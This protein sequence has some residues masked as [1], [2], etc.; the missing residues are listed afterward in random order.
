MLRGD[1][2]RAGRHV[3]E[4]FA[5]VDSAAAEGFE[6]FQ[7][8]NNAYSVSGIIGHLGDLDQQWVVYMRRA[9]HI[10]A[11]WVTLRGGIEFL[12]P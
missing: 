1:N 3:D 5:A 10:G 7:A 11:A 4:V 8:L 2:E 6:Q 12:R 9:E